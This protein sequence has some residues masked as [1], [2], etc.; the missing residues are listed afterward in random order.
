[1]EFAPIDRHC[2]M[3]QPVHE[4]VAIRCLQDFNKFLVSGPRTIAEGQCDQ[5]Q[6]M[7]AEDHW[8]MVAKRA[9]EAQGGGGGLSRTE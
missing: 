7:V 1:M 3:A 6:V 5:M 4:F 9:H 8:C 2:P